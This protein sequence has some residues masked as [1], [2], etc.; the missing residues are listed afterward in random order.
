MNTFIPNAL[1]SGGR[2][3][4]LVLSLMGEVT[5]AFDW[6]RGLLIQVSFIT[7]TDRL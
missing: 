6:R 1:P 2:K 3:R 7:L 4:T 5:Y